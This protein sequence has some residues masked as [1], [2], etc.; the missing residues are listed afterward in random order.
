MG[1][2][3]AGRSSRRALLTAAT[4]AVGVA[5]I[6]AVVPGS[7]SARPVIVQGATGPTG[8]AGPAGPTGPR[9]ATGATGAA[10]PKGATGTAGSA[11]MTGATGPRGFS[12]ATVLVLNFPMGAFFEVS[13][14]VAG[15]TL[16]STDPELIFTFPDGTFPPDANIVMETYI[17]DGDT[18]IIDALGAATSQ[19]GL[20][21]TV[22]VGVGPTRMHFTAM[23]VLTVPV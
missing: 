7:V 10:G 23:N 5:G 12:A 2:T 3:G 6:V 17:G 13:S 16:S 1:D 20:S 19:G 14:S 18:T 9:G 15:T 11:G 21:V 4:S 8:P 22:T